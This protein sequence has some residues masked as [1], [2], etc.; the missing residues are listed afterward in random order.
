MSFFDRVVS[1][2]AVVLT[3]H[4]IGFAASGV[5]DGVNGDAQ[6]MQAVDQAFAGRAGGPCGEH[7]HP[8]DRELGKGAARIEDGV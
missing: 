2:S 5:A 6:A 4:A 8:M 1:G 3:G 7:I